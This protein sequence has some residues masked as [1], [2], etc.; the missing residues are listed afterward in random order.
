MGNKEVLAIVP[1]RSGSKEIKDKNIKIINGK[2]LFFY[3]LRALNMSKKVSRVVVYTD[4]KRYRD[5]VLKY[6][7][8]NFEVYF[9]SFE[10]ASDDSSTEDAILE[11][12][13]V[14]KPEEEYILLTQVTSPLITGKEID[15]FITNFLKKENAESSLSV[16]NIS[17]R[18]VW[19][20]EGPVNYNFEK[21]LRR[22]DLNK[23]KKT[24]IENGALYINSKI[25]WLIY[26]NRLTPPI[27]LFETSKKTFFEVDSLEDFK[28]VEK[29]LEG[30]FNG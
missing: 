2:P 23:D 16:V 3:T 8:E 9:R 26:K 28:I 25:N 19:N 4:S 1:M 17:E 14:F 27:E 24:F 29:I 5:K 7:P 22:Q 11:F 6:F 13:D 20:L 21:R 30:E 12:L 18:F 10:S 15:D